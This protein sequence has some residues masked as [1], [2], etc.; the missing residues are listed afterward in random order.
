M[1]LD[2]AGAGP[3]AG[4]GPAVG[5]KVVRCLPGRFVASSVA[6]GWLLAS[7]LR[8]GAGFAAGATMAPLGFSLFDK[9]YK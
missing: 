4:G 3:G 5:A 8:P 1:K 7:L 9:H 6:S 2:G